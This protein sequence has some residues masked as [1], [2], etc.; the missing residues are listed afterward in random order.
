MSWYGFRVCLTICL[1]LYQDKLKRKIWAKYGAKSS[2][3]YTA[4]KMQQIQR[5][6]MEEMRKKKKELEERRNS[7]ILNGN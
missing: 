7:Q 2:L 1:C 5:E 6:Q 3:D 4:K